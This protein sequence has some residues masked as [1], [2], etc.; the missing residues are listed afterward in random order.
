MTS[1]VHSVAIQCTQN[2]V[3]EEDQSNPSKSITHSSSQH[4]LQA[5]LPY[6]I[7]SPSVGRRW[8]MLRGVGGSGSRS[9]GG[10]MS[11]N[12]AKV[13][14]IG[15]PNTAMAAEASASMP[16]NNNVA[17]G[18]SLFGVFGV[19][20]CCCVFFVYMCGGV[21]SAYTLFLHTHVFPAY[22]QLDKTSTH[23]HTTPQHRPTCNTPQRHIPYKHVL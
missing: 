17:S 7:L 10:R 8:N 23:I 12:K 18:S 11:Q 5:I 15:V 1:N 2:M 3:L 14:H 13:A 16:T 4:S 19:H 22:T 6:A 9:T 20:K 21:F